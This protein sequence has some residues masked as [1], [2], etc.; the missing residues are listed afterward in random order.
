MVSSFAVRPV[1]LAAQ[2]TALSRRRSGVRIPYGLPRRRG[3]ADIREAA[4]SFASPRHLDLL[5]RRPP[6]LTRHPPR[7]ASVILT[8][9][10]SRRSR[11]RVPDET[12]SFGCGLRMT[13]GGGQ[14]PEP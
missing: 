8:K 12:R 14:S 4:M 13:A 3:L 2:D 1:R 7:L 11:T 9:E 10:G 5:A 6:R